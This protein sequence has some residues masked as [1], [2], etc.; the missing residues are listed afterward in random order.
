MSIYNKCTVCGKTGYAN[1]KDVNFVC[2]SCKA[3]K[4]KDSEVKTKCKLCGKIFI[5]VRKTQI[6]CSD[7]CRLLYHKKEYTDKQISMLNVCAKCHK[8]FNTA[9][10]N[11]KYC[12]KLCY[13]EEKAKR[14]K[15]K[16]IFKKELD[17]QKRSDEYG[18][19]FDK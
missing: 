4:R 10:V 17:T 12:S 14:D 11:K 2:V 6:F 18:Q 7:N 16:Y 3:D 15:K 9:K 1:T 5:K 19:N 8:K 13:L